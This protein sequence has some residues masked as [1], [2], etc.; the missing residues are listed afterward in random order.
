[1][2]KYF[3]LALCS[4]LVTYFLS[5]VVITL[6]EKYNNKRTESFDKIMKEQH[7]THKN[8]LSVS[9]ILV[10]TFVLMAL[11]AFP[12]S[13]EPTVGNMAEHLNPAQLVAL[14]SPSVAPSSPSVAPSVM[15]RSMFRSS[16]GLQ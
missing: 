2:L 3:V 8:T 5:L 16:G 10:F 13:A 14:S 12:S 7:K 6:V 15:S 9:A 11:S 1:M 4:G